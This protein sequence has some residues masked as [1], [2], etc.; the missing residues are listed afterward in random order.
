MN[1]VPSAQ[2]RAPKLALNSVRF[3]KTR[4][5]IVRTQATTNHRLLYKVGDCF[6]KLE[7]ITSLFS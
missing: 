4:I 3:S 6:F 1:L 7:N 5:V 2:V